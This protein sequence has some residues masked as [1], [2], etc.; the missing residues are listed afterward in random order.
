MLKDKIVEKIDNLSVFSFFLPEETKADFIAEIEKIKE[1]ITLNLVNNPESAKAA[2]LA[3]NEPEPVTESIEAGEQPSVKPEPEK[4]VNENSVNQAPASIAFSPPVI[5]KDEP[6]ASKTNVEQDE[7]EQKLKEEK[8]QN[9]NSPNQA[10]MAFSPPVIVKDEPKNGKKKKESL[11]NS[12]G[13]SLF[14]AP[15]PNTTTNP[16]NVSNIFN[17]I[18]PDFTFESKVILSLSNSQNVSKLIN[19]IDEK[20]SLLNIFDKNKENF[21]NSKFEFLKL[22]Q[23]LDSQQ[24]LS[25]KKNED[26]NERVAW[27]KFGEL[28]INLG[29]ISPEQVEETFAYKQKNPEKKLFIGNSLVELQYID[30]DTLDYCLKIQDWCN[31]IL[32][33]VSYENA[34]VNAIKEVIE[35]YFKIPCVMDKFTHVAYTEPLTDTI[36]I[37]YNFTGNLNGRIFYICDRS[38]VD[39]LTKILMT[40]YGMSPEDLDKIVLEEGILSKLFN[41]IT[42][43][44]LKLLF[45]NGVFCK[46]D[47][48]KID[49]SE[50][51]IVAE[52]KNI[53]I[54]PL[55]NEAGGFIIGF[56]LNE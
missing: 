4:E 33:K 55:S 17:Y 42:G 45:K 22:I 13:S 15:D 3:E 41:L 23:K 25:Y 56:L 50:N 30:E 26:V 16:E 46:T 43:N 52:K 44:T 24:L 18:I 11:K 10:T 54:I 47:T 37:T 8:V 21:K 2:K 6:K 38:L 1:E 51:V 5:V 49:M 36:C 14:K 34:F 12:T 40:N 48:P 35:D 31:S 53:T 28:A 39:K 32:T 29:L 20:N 7:P 9:G 27:V 19:I